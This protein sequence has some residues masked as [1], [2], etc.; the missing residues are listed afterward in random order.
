MFLAKVNIS[1][2][3][4]LWKLYIIVSSMILERRNIIQHICF[5]SGF[6][7]VLIDVGVLLSVIWNMPFGTNAHMEGREGGGQSANIISEQKT[8]SQ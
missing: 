7:R 4:S 6:R 8:A 2:I 1:E 3:A 5:A